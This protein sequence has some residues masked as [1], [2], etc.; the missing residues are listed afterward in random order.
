MNCRSRVSADD[1]ELVKSHAKLLT[2]EHVAELG[3]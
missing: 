3:S 1:T 2:S